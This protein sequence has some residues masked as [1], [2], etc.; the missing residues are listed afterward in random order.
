[1]KVDVAIIGAGTA[2][3]AA[4]RA[5]KT[6]GA[7]AAGAGAKPIPSNFIFTGRTLVRA[8]EGGNAFTIS[9][10]ESDNVFKKI[11]TSPPS[12]NESFIWQIRTFLAR[13]ETAEAAGLIQ[14]LKNDPNF[15]ERLQTSSTK[16]AT[17]DPRIICLSPVETM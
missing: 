11:W 15:P 7:S 16:G 3:L 12:R 6:A 5:A 2:G 1:M 13:N 17:A 9:T 14:T 8:P 10:K 4:Y